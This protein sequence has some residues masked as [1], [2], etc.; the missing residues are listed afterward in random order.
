VKRL[1]LG[2]LLIAGGAHA[3]TSRELT[4]CAASSLREAF[5]GLVAEFERLHAGTTVHLNLAGSQ[6]L[7]TQIEHLARADVFASADLRHMAALEKAGLV[8]KPAVFARN[9]PVIVVPKGNPAKI[10]ALTDLPKTK[11]LVVGAMEVPIGR[12]T[13]EIFDAAGNKY[14]AELRAK[15]EASVV[16]RELNVR[17][18]LAKVALGEADAGIVY[19]TDAMAAKDQVE[20]VTIPSEL[21]AIAQY[22]IAV[23]K[24]A[25]QPELAAAWTALV[26]SPA[27]QRRLVAAGFLPVTPPAK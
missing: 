21:N 20:V 26:L 3:E 4:V 17:Q 15:L 10:R 18:V 9:E 16:S 13:M 2:L 1:L 11:R 12:Y 22:P 25:P 14:G 8:G 19:R 23:I 6:E 7:R 24:A 5:E 27:G